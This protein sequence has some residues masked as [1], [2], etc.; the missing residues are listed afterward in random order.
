[1]ETNL[2][3]EINGANGFHGVNALNGCHVIN[4][5]NSANDLNGVDNVNGSNKVSNING[6]TAA[7]GTHY[8][9]TAED[10][11]SD[12]GNYDMNGVNGANLVNGNIDHSKHSDPLASTHSLLVYELFKKFQDITRNGN[13]NVN[14]ESLDIPTVV[15]V[16]RYISRQPFRTQFNKLC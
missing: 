6:H 5:A 8:V 12:S 13:V 16:S 9:N 3:D 4:G 15:A 7:N 1:M 10:T 14:G 11:A 2:V